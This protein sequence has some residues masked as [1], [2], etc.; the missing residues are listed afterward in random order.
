MNRL[1]QRI[2]AEA[3]E[4]TQT[5]IEESTSTQSQQPVK[6]DENKSKSDTKGDYYYNTR[7]MVNK[8]KRLFDEGKYD[9][10]RYFEY[11]GYKIFN[12][13]KDET[14]QKEVDPKEYYGEAYENSDFNR[15]N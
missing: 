7:E 9:K 1:L 10:C 5:E 6:E 12:P 4:S 15:V 14:G 11:K 3:D 8:N 2:A 13:F